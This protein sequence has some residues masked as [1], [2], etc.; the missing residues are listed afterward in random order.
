MPVSLSKLR[1]RVDS[2]GT[3]PFAIDIAGDTVNGKHRIEDLSRADIRAIETN[4]TLDNLIG[5][6]IAVVKEWDL[7][8]EDGGPTVPLTRDG[9]EQIPIGALSALMTGIT[10]DVQPPKQTSPASG[11][12]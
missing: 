6:M 3:K 1:S 8:F 2:E 12:G 9:L 10:S 11:A 4:P 5:F 7:T